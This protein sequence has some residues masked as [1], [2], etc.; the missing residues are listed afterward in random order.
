M[1]VSLQP[2]DRFLT[3]VSTDSGDGSYFDNIEYHAPCL[4]LETD[5]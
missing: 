2:A 5:H 1:S 3:L 4:V